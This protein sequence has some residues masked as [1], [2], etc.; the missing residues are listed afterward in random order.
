MFSGEK[1]V[2]AA[3]A[4]ERWTNGVHRRKSS[5]TSI[6]LKVAMRGKEEPRAAPG[7][8]GPAGPVC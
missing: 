2:A 1:M 4:E 8:L 6:Q 5:G 3:Q 7:A